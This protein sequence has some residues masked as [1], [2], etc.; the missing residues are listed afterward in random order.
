AHCP[1]HG[2]ATGEEH[3][4]IRRTKVGVEVA[5]RILKDLGMV[6]PINGVGAKHPAEEQDFGRQKEPHPKLSGLEL[7]L[8]RIEMVR[9][10]PVMLMLTVVRVIGH[11]V[12]SSE[13]AWLISN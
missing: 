13:R 10:K 6:G 1:R 3:Q 4:C 5:T 9:L 12:G 8:P 2:E 7:L 11:V